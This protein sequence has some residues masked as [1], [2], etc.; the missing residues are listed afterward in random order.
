MV[1]VRFWEWQWRWQEW[2]YQLKVWFNGRFSPGDSWGNARGVFGINNKQT[3]RQT[4]TNIFPAP[5]IPMTVMIQTHFGMQVGSCQRQERP[6]LDISFG[7]IL[8][9]GIFW[10]HPGYPLGILLV[11]FW[12]PLGILWVSFGYPLGILWVSFGYPLGIL[13]ASFGPPLG[14]LWAYIRHTLGILWASFGY[15]WVYVGYHVGILWASFG[16][17][18]GVPWEFWATIEHPLGIIWAPH[19]SQNRSFCDS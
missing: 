19:I 18:S 5:A 11:S 14:L 13:W 8:D 7:Q 12:Y 4:N 6:I 16:Y 3:N 9:L 10:G 2:C 1:S 15:P 17:P